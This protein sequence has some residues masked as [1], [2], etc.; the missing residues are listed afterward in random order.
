ME[1]QEPI[2]PTEES[3]E[4]VEQNGAPVNAA[5][6]QTPAPPP[7]ASQPEDLSRMDERLERLGGEPAPAILSIGERRA[8]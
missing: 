8:A 2:N 7:P 1:N 6:A 5:P 3:V 4:N